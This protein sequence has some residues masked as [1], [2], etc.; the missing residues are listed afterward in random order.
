MG[1]TH[2]E[3]KLVVVNVFLSPQRNKQIN[4]SSASYQAGAWA[5]GMTRTPRVDLSSSTSTFGRT[6]EIMFYMAVS[7][8]GYSYL[9]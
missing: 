8:I 4:K 2:H 7:V 6:R 9:Q 5:A 3:L 1:T